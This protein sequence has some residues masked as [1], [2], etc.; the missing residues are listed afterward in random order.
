M[1]QSPAPV[2][3]SD[4]EHLEAAKNDAIA[5]WDGDVRAAPKAAIVA[6]GY[7]ES[8]LSALQTAVSN[9]Y[10]RGNGQRYRVT[11]R[12]GAL[13]QLPKTSPRCRL[14]PRQG[15]GVFRVS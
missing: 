14:L 4:A 1:S 13:R 15:R 10:A 3:L 8:E 9:D 7:L 5:A 2:P 12:I 11:A 6:N